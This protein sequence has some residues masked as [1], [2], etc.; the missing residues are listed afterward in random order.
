[1][2]PNWNT[3]HPYHMY[4]RR[5]SKRSRIKNGI[6]TLEKECRILRCNKKIWY[7]YTWTTPLWSKTTTTINN[8]LCLPAVETR[9]HWWRWCM[10]FREQQGEAALVLCQDGQVQT[11]RGAVQLRDTDDE[12]HILLARITRKMTIFK[13]HVYNWNISKMVDKQ[14]WTCFFLAKLPNH[15]TCFERL[16]KK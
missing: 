5:T 1:M 4:S 12:P 6:T 7:W 16:G 15:Q 10:A 2:Y 3:I 14:F 11:T 13:G 9:C 8:P